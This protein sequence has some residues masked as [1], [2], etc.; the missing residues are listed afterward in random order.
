MEHD[1]GALS[2]EW[3]EAVWNRRDDSTMARLASPTLLI[4]GLGED[5]RPARGLDQFTAFRRTFLSAFPDLHLDVE[6]VL[7]DGDQTAVRLTFAGTHTG[8]GI[9]I[10]PTGRAITST[11]IAIARWHDGRIVES[12]NEFDAAGM[13]RQLQS[14]QAKLRV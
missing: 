12:W 2:R 7:V 13:I 11:A 9:G 3:F 4:H 14:P 5:G 8:D 6:D 1:I 10:A